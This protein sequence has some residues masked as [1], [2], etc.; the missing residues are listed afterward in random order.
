MSIEYYRSDD[1]VENFSLGVVVQEL[2]SEADDSQFS[3]QPKIFRQSLKWQQKLHSPSEIAD[4]A[5]NQHNRAVGSA[6]DLE[7]RLALGRLER[8][9]KDPRAALADEV[10][11]YTLVDRDIRRSEEASESAYSRP[12]DE[13]DALTLPSALRCQ[14]DRQRQR[15]GDSLVRGKRMRVCLATDIRTKQLLQERHAALGRFH[16]S[17]ASA[18][19]AFDRFYDEHVLLQLTL[20]EDGLIEVSPPLSKPVSEPASATGTAKSESG[21]ASD[22]LALSA[23]LDAAPLSVFLDEQTAEQALRRGLL[24]GTRKLRAHHS[25]R[26]FQVALFNERAVWSPLALEARREDAALRDSLRAAVHRPALPLHPSPSLAHLVAKPGGA[27][28]SAAAPPRDALDVYLVELVHAAGFACDEVCVAYDVAAPPGARLLVDRAAAVAPAPSQRRAAPRRRLRGRRD[29]RLGAGGAVALVACAA[30]AVGASWLL[31]L[32]PV[33]GLVVFSVAR[34]ADAAF[35]GAAATAT[36]T[37]AL[38]HLVAVRV[39]RPAAPPADEVRVTVAVYGRGA[40]DRG[41]L[42]GLAAFPLGR[43]DDRD[44]FDVD[45]FALR[46]GAAADLRQCFLGHAVQ[47][48]QTQTQTRA[49]HAPD[50]DVLHRWL[51]EASDRAR[52]G[53]L[54]EFAG[55]L[56]VRVQRLAVAPPATGDR[57]SDAGGAKGA[58]PA[59]SVESGAD[60]GALEQLRS[61]RREQSM[62]AEQS[63]KAPGAA[64]TQR[65]SVRSILDSLGASAKRS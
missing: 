34:R 43:A 30:S 59:G 36:A 29:E 35:D 14:R 8:E 20:F 42:L 61:L 44:A 16:S 4:Y 53:S 10:L 39:L 6:V 3:V 54:S 18:A 13:G 22:P 17:G 26:V 5:H 47:L 2:V 46:G 63:A 32:A 24:M 1:P 41:V 9:G 45:C 40:F 21:A 48:K 11:L 31:W 25:G 65:P 37:A 57:P 51:A 15:R 23:L 7:N 60:S 12:D 27:P 38:N 56:R 50:A 58:A 28:S 19:A 33:L 62:R 64:A 52:F 55:T 49:A